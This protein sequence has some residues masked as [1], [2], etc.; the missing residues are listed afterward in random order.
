[1]NQYEMITDNLE[2]CV[3]VVILSDIP[4]DEFEPVEAVVEGVISGQ[5]ALAVVLVSRGHFSSSI[6]H[7]SHLVQPLS[8]NDDT[9]IQL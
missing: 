8:A 4:P 3:S 6:V 5:C 7:L 1:M 2:L 9:A